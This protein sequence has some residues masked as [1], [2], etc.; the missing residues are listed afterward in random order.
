MEEVPAERAMHWFYGAR[1]G[2]LLHGLVFSNGVFSRLYGWWQNRS[3]TRRRIRP[4]V[5]RFQIDVD[6]VEDALDQYPTFN[7]FFSRRLRADARPFAADPEVLCSPA[8]G[9]VLVSI[10]D[11]AR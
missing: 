5:E 11:L 7:A 1:A 8:D 4:F 6:E 3:W 10:L 9:R 2:G